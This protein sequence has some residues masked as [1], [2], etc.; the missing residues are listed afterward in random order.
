MTPTKKPFRLSKDELQEIE[1]EIF[2]GICNSKE[3][4][5]SLLNSQSI[6]ASYT[7]HDSDDDTNS[8]VEVD[9]I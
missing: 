4:M 2:M 7:D 9:E 8:A 6:R 5:M 3:K 1:K